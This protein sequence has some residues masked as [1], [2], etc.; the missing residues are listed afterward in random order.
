MKKAIV[1][2]GHGAG[3][4]AL[5]QYEKLLEMLREINSDSYLIMLHGS[6]KAEDVAIK[7]KELKVEYVTLIPILLAKGHHME[8]NIV[9]KDCYIQQ[10]F[11]KRDIQVNVV[12]KGLL[13]YTD[14]RKSIVDNIFNNVPDNIVLCLNE[15]SIKIFVDDVIYHLFDNFPL[16]ASIVRNYKNLILTLRL[17]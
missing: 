8:N 7:L 2:I 10:E 5:L 12:N 15:N 14:I 9:S 17:E 6:P 1:I 3:D 13:E 4:E 11:I 16:I